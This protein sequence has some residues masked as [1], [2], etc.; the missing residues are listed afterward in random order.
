MEIIN[1]PHPTLRY[2]SKPIVRVDA[3]LREIVGE[4]FDLMYAAKGVGL[5]ANQVNLPLQLFVINVTGQRDSGEELVFINPVVSAPRGSSVASEG[6]LSLAG[7]EAMVSRP[8]QIHVS[9]YDLSGNEID[10]TVGGFLARV[11]QHEN[12]HIR[13]VM[14]VDRISDSERRLIEGEI[15]AFDLDF[16]AAREA[17][18][19]PDDDAIAEHRSKIE[20]R[21]CE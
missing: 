3:G 19:I 18:T 21:Y 6:C 8:E 9:A 15:E 12:D 1:F 5:A 7:V 14:F 2:E 20:A 11:I 13:G 16:T 4:M 10:M 17:G